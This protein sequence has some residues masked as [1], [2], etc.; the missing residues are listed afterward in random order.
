MGR[1]PTGAQ[2]RQATLPSV[3]RLKLTLETCGASQRRDPTAMEHQFF[4][5]ANMSFDVIFVMF[6]C[7]SKVCRKTHMDFVVGIL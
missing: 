7:T 1:I 6:V 5:K 3:E 4:W 2:N